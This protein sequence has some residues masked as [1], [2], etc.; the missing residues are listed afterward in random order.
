MRRPAFPGQ[1]PAPSATL[2]F[3]IRRQAGHWVVRLCNN[4]YGEYLNKEQARLDALDA[5]TEAREAGHEA[6]VWDRSTNVRV[7]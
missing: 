3:E 2:I 1:L 7:F 6:E 4:L 5:A